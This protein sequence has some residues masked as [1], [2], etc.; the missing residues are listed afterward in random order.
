MELITAIAYAGRSSALR[1]WQWHYP[2]RQFNSVQFRPSKCM[3][4][5]GNSN[6]PP[7]SEGAVLHP[8]P[9]IRELRYQMDNCGAT[10][11]SQFCFGGLA[12]LLM[13]GL[14]DAVD[15]FFMVVG[16]TK[17]GPD[18]LARA[19]V[20][21]YQRQDT[22]NFAMFMQNVKSCANGQAYDG[23][24]ILRD[25]RAASEKLFRA[26]DKIMSYRVFYLVGDDGKMALGAPETIPADSEMLPRSGPAYKRE[27]LEK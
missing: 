6:A 1:R 10:N 20:G 8:E 27:A 16:H 19:I 11:K 23:S 22:L 9:F 21:V 15:T 14:L 24:E 3:E 13:F 12:L 26:V 2:L 5:P 18:D 4:P 25:F 7:E 17:F